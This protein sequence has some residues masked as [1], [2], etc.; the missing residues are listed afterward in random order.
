MDVN[1]ILHFS[2]GVYFFSDIVETVRLMKK[3]S[4]RKLLTGGLKKINKK[5][6]F[7][8]GRGMNNNKK[9]PLDSSNVFLNIQYNF[10]NY[11][12]MRNGKKL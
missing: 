3:K 8:E 9:C 1:N 7:W 5:K 11:I 6:T 2:H 10:I 12:K 4:N